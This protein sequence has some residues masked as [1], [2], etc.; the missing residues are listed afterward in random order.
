MMR[1]KAALLVAVLA[2]SAS[3]VVAQETTTIEVKNGEVLAVHGNELVFRG[4]EGVKSV[5]VPDDFRFI[6]GGKEFT[7]HQLKPG[8][9]L[10]AEIVTTT[11]PV[12]MTVTEVKRGEIVYTQGGAVIVRREDGTLTKFTTKTLKE[13]GA[14]ITKGGK[15]IDLTTLRTG[16]IIEATVVSRQPPTM[17]TEQEMKVY[18]S[19]PA[20]K[21]QQPQ[22]KP[23]VVAQAKPEQRPQSLPKTASPLPLIAAI[24]LALLAIAF[25]LTAYRRFSER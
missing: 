15:P 23:V 20:P 8:M 9:K 2:L 24:G 22:P 5:N 21:R 7:V 13:S 14:V 6:M 17:V 16:D 19:N 18:A 3:A 1:G 4:P 12:E 25:G 10:T 11:R